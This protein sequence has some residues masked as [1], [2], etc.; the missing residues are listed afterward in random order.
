MIESKT[1][2]FKFSNF[3]LEVL[4]ISAAVSDDTD[5]GTSSFFG[6]QR[7]LVFEGLAEIILFLDGFS[8]EAMIGESCS[9][10]WKLLCTGSG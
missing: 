1:E 4:S 9:S 3:G 10:K 2:N 6:G 8:S 5:P 7:R